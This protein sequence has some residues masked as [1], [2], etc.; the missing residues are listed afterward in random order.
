MRPE[1]DYYGRQAALDLAG[2]R[3]A[4]ADSPI[5][6]TAWL[7]RREMLRAQRSEISVLL[8]DGVISD[9]VYGE[10]ISQIDAGLVELERMTESGAEL[11]RARCACLSLLVLYWLSLRRTCGS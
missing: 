8:R 5:T 3:Q 11:H 2:A 7:A 6:R 10:M 1:L 9:E 4:G